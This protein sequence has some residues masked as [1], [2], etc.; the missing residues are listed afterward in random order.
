MLAGK[1]KLAS[2]CEMEEDATEKYVT[3]PTVKN[4]DW[5]KTSEGLQESIC[6]LLGMND[7]S[8]SYVVW[9]Q[10]ILSDEEYNPLN[11]Y[12][13]IEEQMITRS[14][15]LVGGTVVTIEDFEAS[16]TFLESY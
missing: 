16:G 1:S 15:I 5:Q 14:L 13:N 3:T 6:T 9:K 8:M 11:G 12:N 2:S 10:H 7:T 4:N